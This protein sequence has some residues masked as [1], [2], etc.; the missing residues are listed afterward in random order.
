[1]LAPRTVL[2]AA[3][4]MGLFFTSFDSGWFGAEPPPPGI[5]SALL[6]F[7]VLFGFGA[8]A[9]SRVGDHKRSQMFAG[10]AVA[11]AAYGLGRLV[12]G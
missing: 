4:L 6:V 2:V 8:W 10:V 7:G 5:S 11:A 12:I 9:T 1:M 3:V